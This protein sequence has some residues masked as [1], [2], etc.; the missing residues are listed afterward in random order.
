MKAMKPTPEQIEAELT[1]WRESESA[2]IE[3]RDQMVRRAHEA[4]FNIRKIHLLSGISRPAIYRIL[5]K[6]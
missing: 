1:G 3:R 6:T 5:E 4:G 2:R